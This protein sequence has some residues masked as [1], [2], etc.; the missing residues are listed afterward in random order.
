MGNTYEHLFSTIKIGNRLTLK[1]R[2]SV[3]AMGTGDMGGTRGEYRDNTIEYYLERARGGFGLI[4]LGSVIVDMETDKPN[5]IDG[6]VPPSYAPGKWRESACRLVERIHYYGAKTFMQI[7]FGHGRMRPGQKA[8]SPI[9]RYAD[10]SEITGV[11]TAEE[12]E[13]KIGYMIKTAKMAK[14]AGFDGVEVH[15]MHWGYLLDQMAMEISNQRDDEYGGTLEKRLTCARKIVEGIKAECGQDF[16]VAMRMGMKS[17]IKGFNQASI[18][19]TEEAGRT[20]E[21][22]VEIAKLL[23]RFGYDMLDVNS[24]IYDSF[25]YCVAPAYIPKGYNLYLS[26]RLK[27]AVSIPVFTAGRMDDPN[28]CEE[29]VR[30]N[31]TDGVALGRASLADPYYVKK[32]QMGRPEKIRPC[33][34]CG[35]CMASAFNKGSATCT[36]NPQ[37]MK[38]GL[39]GMTKAVQPKHVVVV[40]GGVC[41]MEAARNAA[42]RGH[43]VELLERA[44]KLGGRLFDAGVHSFKGSIRALNEWYIGELKDL[45]V[46]V[47]MN[48]EATPE[49]LKAS[50]ADTV[51]FAIGSE[52]LMPRAIE[53]IDSKKAVACTDILLGKKEA[54]QKVVIVGGGLVGA[55]MAYDMGAEGKEVYLVEALDDICA[56]DPNGVPFWVRDMLN[57]LLSRNHVE[58]LMGHRLDRITDKGAVVLDKDGNQKEIEAD[59]VIIAI[60]FRARPSICKELNGCGIETFDIVAGNGIG[61]ITT[62]IG[63]AYEITRKL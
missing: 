45:G 36:V 17:Y 58:K 16:P 32:L 63:A 11:L 3:A 29:A 10:P 31:E 49:L 19:G 34:A 56:N 57:E 7:G 54:G 42:A 62:Q 43:E 35:N 20:I 55:E 1:N 50:G 14:E 5:L 33:I 60:G 23:E 28:L 18:D 48:T 21:E 37:G 44:D 38:E 24:G 12:I 61:S 39:Y 13:T 27:E 46:R 8:P 30:N 53:G 41:G 59:D 2:F 52:P 51:I 15:A 4:V 6:V 25:Y 40:G 47:R 22:A 9:P 26:K